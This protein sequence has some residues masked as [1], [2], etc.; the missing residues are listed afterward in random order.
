MILYCRKATPFTV[1]E[2]I[3]ILSHPDYQKIVNDPPCKAIGGDVFLY[4]FK[5][6]PQKRNDWRCDQYRWIRS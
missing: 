4:S 2:A 3:D 5:G 1:E 6:S